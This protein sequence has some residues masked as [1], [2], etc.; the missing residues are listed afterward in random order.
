MSKAEREAQVYSRLDG[1]T[2]P[3]ETYSVVELRGITLFYKMNI[4]NLGNKRKS[5]LIKAISANVK[6]KAKTRR[7]E[8]RQIAAETLE[9]RREKK[10]REVIEAREQREMEQLLR[11]QQTIGDA[12][13]EK[14]VRTS[15]TYPDW[16]AEELRFELNQSN[17]QIDTDDI[18]M[19][20]FLFFGYD[21][22][23]PERYK[24][25]DRRP[26]A[27]MLKV[28]DDNKILGYNI[29]YL[30]PSYRGTISESMLN[31]KVVDV[32]DL[33]EKGLHSYIIGN[34]S[35]IYRIPRNVG[36]Y[37]DIAK[38]ITEDFVDENGGK[39]DIN[40]VWDSVN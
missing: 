40:A 22:R 36:E 28:V 30:N 31:K 38:L 33:P 18:R 8:Q 32:G 5:D 9:E 6:Y 11:S 15:N 13:L 3:L 19:G 24:Y 14:G 34:M 7:V 2:R 1:T 20:D 4:G 10:K 25:Y 21:A 12:I 37:R 16:Y 27:F 35:N 26:L 23:F 17:T 39:Y 29:H